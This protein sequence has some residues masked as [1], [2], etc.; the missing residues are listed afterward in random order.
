MLQQFPPSSSANLSDLHNVFLTGLTL[1]RCVVAL[2]H[3][4]SL[5]DLMTAIG[6]CS[7]SLFFFAQ[8]IKAV[9]A[10]KPFRDAFRESE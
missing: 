2:A 7:S 3:I 10:A 5:K 9:K 8:Y 4:L 1:L 6:A